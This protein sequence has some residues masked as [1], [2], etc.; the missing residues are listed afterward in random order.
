MT[1]GIPTNAAGHTLSF[2]AAPYRPLSVRG[3]FFAVKTEN[4][5]RV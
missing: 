4:P 2:V 1:G 5:F 3:V